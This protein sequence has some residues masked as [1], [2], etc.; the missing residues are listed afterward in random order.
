MKILRYLLFV[1]SL[2]L[3]T[4]ACGRSS[5]ESP[6]A[7]TLDAAIQQTVAAQMTA[8]PFVTATP[9]AIPVEAPTQPPIDVTFPPPATDAPPTDPPPAT[10]PG[11]T[12]A[13][14]LLARPN[15][16]PLTARRVTAAPTIDGDVSEWGALPYAIDQVTF[17]P[18]NWKDATDCSGLFMLGWDD[19][20]LYVAV[21]VKD[22]VVT[23]TQTGELIF[24]GDSLEVIIDA[25]LGADFVDAKLSSDDYQLGLSPGDLVK[26]TPAVEAYLWFPRTKKGTPPG[27]VVAARPASDGY[28]VEAAIP[29]SVYGLAPSLNNRYGFALSISDNDNTNAAEQQT[30]VSSVKTRTLTNPTTWGTMVLG[31]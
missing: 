16:D 21:Q 19:Q 12:A 28:T 8:Q 15:G 31:E 24:K 27:V 6:D 14:T 13:P 3:L 5:G 20:N 10:A 7:A 4:L 29:W 23:Q 1:V 26:G 25:N 22:D 11:P 9:S 30:L 2:L 17:K 18:E